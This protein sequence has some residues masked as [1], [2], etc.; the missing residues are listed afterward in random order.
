MIISVIT[1][2]AGEDVVKLAPTYYWG[3]HQLGQFL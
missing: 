3:Q 1:L 2:N